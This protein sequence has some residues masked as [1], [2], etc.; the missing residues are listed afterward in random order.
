LVFVRGMFD[1]LLREELAGQAVLG[2]LKLRNEG[3]LPPNR[4]K[5]SSLQNYVLRYVFNINMYPSQQTKLDLSVLLN[6]S[7]KAIN[8]WFQ[9]ERQMG[10]FVKN[11]KSVKGEVSVSLIFKIYGK[12]L[13]EGKKK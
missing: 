1:D 12:G 13:K 3:R 10:K 8:V 11:N 5:K 7:I 9:N 4:N 6:L 2:L